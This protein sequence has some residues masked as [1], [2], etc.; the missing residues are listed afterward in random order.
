MRREKAK[1]K[2]KVFFNY[3]TNAGVS[4]YRMINFAKFMSREKNVEVAYTK[5]DPN[6]KGIV[7]WEQEIDSPKQ[8]QICK[9]MFM[10]HQNADVAIWQMVHSGLSLD[11]FYQTRDMWDNKKPLLM[12]IDDYVHAINPESAGF[13]AYHNNSD[14]EYFAELQMK[15]ANHLIVSTDWLAEKYKD[16]CPCVTVIPN[17]IDFEIWDQLEDHRK[18]GRIRIGWAGGQPHEKDL[19][20]LTKVIPVILAKYKNVDFMFL[21]HFPDY[22]ETGERVHHIQKWYSIYD[23]PKEISKLGIDIGVAPLRDNQFNR[24]K[25]NLRFLEYSALGIPTVASPVEP[26]NKNFLGLQALEA[27]EWIDK[28]SLLIENEDYRL[29]MG[30]GAKAFVKLKFNAKDTAKMYLKV[31]K[32]ICAGKKPINKLK[33]DIKDGQVFGSVTT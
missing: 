27:D 17:A 19:K 5:Y 6:N 8:E 2:F 25:S 9:D 24:A 21:G 18:P 11:M 4:Y 32:D 13:S 30:R 26:F 15:N 20:V 16:L 3:T 28:L 1:D 29:K 14:L 33:Y 22:L 10:L 12:D 31:L 7:E 23:Y